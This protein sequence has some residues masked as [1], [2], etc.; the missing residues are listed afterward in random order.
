MIE[1]PLMRHDLIARDCA[2]V[3]R[4]F[5]YRL[6]PTTAQVEV[7]T[8]Q[9]SEACRLYNAALQ[10]RRDAWA[11]QR[12]RVSLFDQGLQLKSIRA[13][14]DIQLPN[15]AVARNVLRSVDRAFAA[16]FRRAKAKERRAGFPRFKASRTFRTLTFDYGTGVKL[17]NGNR[18]RLQGVGGVRLRVHRPLHGKI[19]T[20]S[21]RRECGGWYACFSVLT[22]PAGLEP[23][24]A[25]IG[26]DVGLTAFATLSD[27]SQI[28]NPRYFRKAERKLRIAQR[29][30]ARRTRGS[31]RRYKAARGVEK[32]HARVRRQ[33]ADFLH[34]ASRDVV[35]GFG[36][37]AVEDL[38]VSGLSTSP[39]AKSVYDAGW[40][41]FINNLTY[42]AESAGREV[43][44]V[45]PS[46]TS[47]TCKCGARVPKGLNQR[48]HECSEC[49]LSL[50]RDHVSALVILGRGRRLHAESAAEV[51]A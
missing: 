41:I 24:Q 45:N 49:G 43:V 12:K 16:F 42:K 5:R 38:N 28:D 6:Y 51:L 27:G 32:A 29:R 8:L 20:V 18:L 46:G 37:I 19:K 2:T 44:R 11:M 14:G 36:L 47:Q 23:S 34:K 9:L 1:D 25:A 10:E 17:L 13:D 31:R 3:S 30:V 22:K 26:I 33:R 21:V 40:S 35:N 4:T 7:L 39:V 50:S 15:F 48:W